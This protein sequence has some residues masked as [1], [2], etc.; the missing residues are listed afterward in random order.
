MAILLKI[1]MKRLNRWKSTFR[2]VKMSVWTRNVLGA[3]NTLP[4]YLGKGQYHPLNPINHMGR[5][6]FFS[7]YTMILPVVMIQLFI[8]FST[9]L[10]LNYYL[11]KWSR[12]RVVFIQKANHNTTK[13]I[14]DQWVSYGFFY[15]TDWYSYVYVRCIPTPKNCC[16]VQNAYQKVNSQ[17]TTNE[18][19]LDKKVYNVK[20]TSILV[21]LCAD[22]RIICWTRNMFKV[23]NV[24]GMSWQRGTFRQVWSFHVCGI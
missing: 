5:M 23:I 21:A 11:M 24:Q 7:T 6:N 14:T 9:S 17:K 19:M 16:Y 12:V 15:L 8:I 10:L 18:N 2:V 4:R 13:K 22:Q 3:L 1:L 20:M